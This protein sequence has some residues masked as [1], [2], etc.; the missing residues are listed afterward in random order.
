MLADT[1]QVDTQLQRDLTRII[2]QVEIQIPPIEIR[3][4]ID[5]SPLQQLQ[6]NANDSGSSIGRLAGIVAGA[7]GSIAKLTVGAAAATTAIGGIGVAVGSAVTALGGMTG[8]VNQA[9]GALGVFAAARGV[10]TIALSGISDAFGAL[11]EDAAKFEETI[12][13][14][15]PAAQSVAREFRAAVPQFTAFRNALQE[16]LFSQI[17]GQNIAARFA[18]ALAQIQ[19]AAQDVAAAFGGV[20]ERLANLA[21]QES[22]IRNLQTILEATAPI[23]ERLG[24]AF[25]DFLGGALERAAAGTAEFGETFGVLG[26]AFNAVRDVVT[27]V[28]RIFGA[29]TDAAERAGVSL[30]GPLASALEVVADLFESPAGTAFLDTMIKLGQTLITTLVP[31]LTTLLGALAP[32][33]QSMGQALIPV[34]RELGPPLEL[35]IQALGQALTPIIQA[36]GP[37]LVAVTSALGALVRAVS[38]LLP[39]VGTL[40]AGLLTALTPAFVGLEQ[41]IIALTPFVA[42]LADTLSAVLEPIL[43]SLPALIEGVIT[44]SVELAE[45]L[46][47]LL[48]Q[49]LQELTPS[50]VILAGALVK[51]IPA[52]IPVITFST[53]LATYV[54]STFAPAIR[55]GISVIAALQRQFAL[56]VSALAG[57]VATAVRLF[58]RFT[59]SARQETDKAI[60]A[61]RALP[62]RASRALSNIGSTLYSAGRALISGFIDGIRSMLGSVRDAA[63]D[64]VGAARDYFPFSPA[65]VGPLSGN[66]FTDVAGEQLIRGFIAGVRAMTP[67]LTRTVSQ[68]LATSTSPL[69]SRAFSP[70]VAGGSPLA[71]APVNVGA[72]QVAV[73]IG[74]ERLAGF[75]DTQIQI[76]RRTTERR[77]AQGIR[78]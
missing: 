24:A 38:P 11:T 15:A 27:D 26:N 19:P 76:D 34:I 4:Q 64:I 32:L 69:T 67:E 75:I 28:G 18:G 31:V 10:L 30:G 43:A 78:R 1:S 44:P 33:I 2:Q 29:I 36:L 23:V 50:L 13:G 70:A 22:T 63:G 68:S 73:Y 37:V 42:Q 14:L 9:A 12:E 55:L 40:V 71:M 56:L 25:T 59:S 20:F 16:S 74:N 54:I 48:T 7:V 3:I 41:I 66:G 53:R 46:G 39:I 6:R 58:S 8:I 35:L 72:P 51:L 49:A 57:G 62:S 60:D 61:V 47:P 21:T 17:Q 5:Q 77:A 52:I 65:K 45:V